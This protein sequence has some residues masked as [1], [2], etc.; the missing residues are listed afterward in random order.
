MPR[1]KGLLSN[2]LKRQSSQHV[3]M[4]RTSLSGV[5]LHYMYLERKFG[6]VKACA[7]T[8]VACR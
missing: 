7:L 2:I 1:A 4:F 3:V 6:Q 8:I 5:D